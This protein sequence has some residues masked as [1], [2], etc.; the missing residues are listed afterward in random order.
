MDDLLY[1]S[2]AWFSSPAEAACARSVFINTS[3]LNESDVQFEANHPSSPLMWKKM[4]RSRCGKKC[5]R[6]AFIVSSHPSQLCLISELSQ[7]CSEII[8]TV[9]KKWQQEKTSVLFVY[10]QCNEWNS[11]C[12]L[13]IHLKS[14]NKS[15]S[16]KPFFHG[17]AHPLYSSVNQPIKQSMF[18]FGL[19]SDR[20]DFHFHGGGH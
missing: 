8:M 5:D 16:M 3:L 17:N 11:F 19:R 13:F 10:S 12:L 4:S 14:R 6:H 9:L 20:V 15:F 7:H 2:L 1:D 18:F